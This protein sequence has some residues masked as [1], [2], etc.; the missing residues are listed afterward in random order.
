MY[1]T[2][3]YCT[4][5]LMDTDE[6]KQIMYQIQFLDAFGLKEY[7]D[8]EINEKISSIYNKIKECPQFKEMCKACRGTAYECE[9]FKDNKEEENEEIA[10]ICF[11]S[12]DTFDSFHKCLVD[13]FTHG[14]I[15]DDA[16]KNMLNTIMQIP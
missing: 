7:N 14:S 5:K 16:K 2:S 3:F 6:D 15:L 12:F 9:Q 10:F 1:D 11:F 13:F 8:E 4:Y